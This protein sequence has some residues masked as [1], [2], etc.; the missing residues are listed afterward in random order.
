MNVA[1]PPAQVWHT[2]SDIL[3]IET[4]SKSILMYRCVMN[5]SLH[6]FNNG[7]MAM[8]LQLH[9]PNLHTPSSRTTLWWTYKLG[10]VGLRSFDSLLCWEDS[11]VADRLR[12]WEGGV[13]DREREDERVFDRDLERVLRRG[14][15]DG[16]LD[17][18]RDLDLLDERRGLKRWKLS[19]DLERIQ[20]YSLCGL[21]LISIFVPFTNMLWEATVTH[22]KLHM[23]RVK[24]VCLEVNKNIIATSAILKCH[25]DF[26]FE[27]RCSTSVHII[28]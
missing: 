10:G 3:L 22:S 20:T 12:R 1:H 23:T 8:C 27:M 7:F 21:T 6:K 18:D 17:R 15:G 26:I 4:E 5:W 28:S 24:W 16:D 9:A 13:L 19:L 2:A 25:L 11:G 14:G